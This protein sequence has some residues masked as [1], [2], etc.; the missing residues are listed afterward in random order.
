MIKWGILGLG[1][2]AKRFLNSLAFH[3]EG[4][5]YVAGSFTPEKRK[6]FQE[7]YPNMKIY[8]NYQQVIED[9]QV[10]AVYIALPHKNHYEWALKSLQAGK[11]V[12]CEKPATLSYQETKYLCEVSKENKILFIEGLKTR[13][14]PM[15]Q[16]LKKINIGDIERVETSFCYQRDYESNQFLFDFEQGGILNDVGSYCL[17]TIIDWIHSPVSQINSQVD[18]FHKVDAENKVELIFQSGQTALLEMSLLTERERK[19][20]ICGNLGKIE[21]T[22]FYRPEEAIITMKTGEIIKRSKAY[23][24]DDFYTEIEE[25]HQCLRKNIFES[26]KMPHQ[27]SITCAK[28]MSDI[29]NQQ[30]A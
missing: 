17:G 14:I 6:D 22:P 21:A 26:P 15:R 25:V 29:R 19:M 23:Q 12:L 9:S 4:I 8:D 24:Y 13:F 7:Q 27:D 18:Y 11:A 30:N 5:A 28:I 10:D 16:E 3:T 20:T 2:I 1:T